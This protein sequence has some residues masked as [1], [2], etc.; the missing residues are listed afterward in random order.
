MGKESYEWAYFRLS[1]ECRHS[2]S[3][4]IR[5]AAS[6]GFQRLSQPTLCGL[7]RAQERRFCLYV[8]RIA[9]GRI[10]S[11][12]KYVH[13]DGLDGLGFTVH[14]TAHFFGCLPTKDGF[15][16]VHAHRRW[17]LFDPNGFPV[18]VED[19][20]DELLLPFSFAA[21]VTSKHGYLT[22]GLGQRE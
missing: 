18:D 11:E 22:A 6:F 15:A 5:W 16:A 7:Q 9:R 3:I 13:L 8:L 12:G 14:H 17:N 2:R 20:A 4:T 10:L 1:V 19:F 21:D